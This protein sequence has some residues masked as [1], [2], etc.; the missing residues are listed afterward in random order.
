[1]RTLLLAVGVLLFYASAAAPTEPLAGLEKVAS[2]YKIKILAADPEFP[3]KTQ[4]GKI[5]GKAA[6]EAA[7]AKYTP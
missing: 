3:V 4:H 6:S 1:M 5:D 7:L 2:A